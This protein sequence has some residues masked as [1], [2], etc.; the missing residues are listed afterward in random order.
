MFGHIPVLKYLLKQKKVNVNA[1]SKVGEAGYE[2]CA[3]D[4]SCLGLLGLVC[5]KSRSMF[6]PDLQQSASA[7]GAARTRKMSRDPSSGT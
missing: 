1:W 2:H 6:Q 4:H 5:R 3:K 7:P